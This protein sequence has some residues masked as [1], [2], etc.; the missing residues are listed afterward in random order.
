MDQRQVHLHM[1][2]PHEEGTVS[3]PRQ[4]SPKLLLGHLRE[5]RG[6]SH[7]KAVQVYHWQNSTALARMKELAS[8]PGTC[9]AP[10]LSFTIA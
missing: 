8:M 7:F 2:R 9:Y 4:V 10:G 3:T 6:R 1:V 5:E